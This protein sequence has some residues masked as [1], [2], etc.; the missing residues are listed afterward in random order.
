MLSNMYGAG[1]PVEHSRALGRFR[2][3]KKANQIDLVACCGIFARKKDPGLIITYY[4]LQLAVEITMLILRF[5][6]SS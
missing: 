4:N 5:L 6:C 2:S 3:P 1:G